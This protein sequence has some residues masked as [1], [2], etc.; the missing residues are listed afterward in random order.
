MKEI[1]MNLFIK[2]ERDV[3]EGMAIVR[4]SIAIVLLTH[5]LHG[6][7]YYEGLSN[8]GSF[9]DSLGFPFGTFMAWMVVLSQTVCSF[10]MIFKRFVFLSCIVNILILAVG[11]WTVHASHGWY[12]V[13][14]GTS[15]MEF[16]VLLIVCLVGVLYEYIPSKKLNTV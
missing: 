9:L 12:V 3:N 10:L 2:P 4:I 5:G 11:T 7:Y 15:G 1:N 8:F 14:A 6:L 16:S 13:G